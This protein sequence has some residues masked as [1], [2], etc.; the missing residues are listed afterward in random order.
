ML[1]SENINIVITITVI[2]NVIL[3]KLFKLFNLQVQIITTVFSQIPELWPDVCSTSV[4]PGVSTE[5]PRQYYTHKAE[6][7]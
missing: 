7:V 4:Y 5:S 6:V 3:S 2:L 1:G